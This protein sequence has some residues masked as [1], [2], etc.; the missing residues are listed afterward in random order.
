MTLYVSIYSYMAVPWLI[1]KVFWSAFRWIFLQSKFCMTNS[2]WD[3]SRYIWM[4]SNWTEARISTVV[5]LAVLQ[6]QHS[7]EEY[8]AYCNAYGVKFPIKILIIYSDNLAAYKYVL[9][10]VWGLFL[11]PRIAD[12]RTW[13]YRDIRAHISVASLCTSG[14]QAGK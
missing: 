14:T 10:R 1:W 8:Y 11:R 3:T 2:N 9:G 5:F 6:I 4:S 12:W 13:A 7:I